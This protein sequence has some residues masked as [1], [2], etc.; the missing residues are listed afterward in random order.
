MEKLKAWWKKHM[1][2]VKFTD[3]R[4]KELYK[5]L[6]REHHGLAGIVLSLVQE[7]NGVIIDN[8]DNSEKGIKLS[9]YDS[10]DTFKNEIEIDLLN[11][12]IYVSRNKV[13]Y[14]EVYDD[15]TRKNILPIAH[16]YEG[17]DRKIIKKI[18]YLIGDKNVKYYELEERGSTYTI[19]LDVKNN[20]FEEDDFIQKILYNTSRYN[21]I[22]DLFVTINEIVDTNCVDV[23]LADSKGGNVV[24]QDGKVQKYVEYIE[25]DN[26]YTKIY[27]QNGE[28]Y[29][30]RRVK[31]QYEDNLTSYIKKMGEYDGKEKR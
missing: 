5:R 31:E 22:R 2:N 14:Q 10:T 11:K 6:I 30:E 27:M 1:S 17:A 19:L 18:S 15:Y 23:K 24:I 20:L 3:E 13:P 29:Y 28:F 8:I 12:K 7:N 16:Q 4:I 9:V 25:E 26:Q 21:S